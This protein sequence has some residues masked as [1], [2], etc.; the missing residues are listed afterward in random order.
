[1]VGKFV[2]RLREWRLRKSLVKFQREDFPPTYEGFM[3][4]RFLVYMSTRRPI[5][6]LQEKENARP[7]PPRGS[8][9]P[10]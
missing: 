2:R 7:G 5:P 1:M 3:M 4:Y 9:G 8:S 6:L 10:A